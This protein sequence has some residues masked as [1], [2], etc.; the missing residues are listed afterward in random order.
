M[1]RAVHLRAALIA[2][3]GAAALAGA[4][5]TYAAAGAPAPAPCTPTLTTVHGT[6]AT[7]YCGPA[8]V[9]I[10]IGGRTYHFRGGLCDLSTQIGALVLSVGTLVRGAPGNGGRAFVGLVIA[11]SP[12]TSEAFEADAG[13]RQLFGDS[14]IAQGGHLLGRGT[15][16][17]ILGPAFSGSWNCHGVIHSGP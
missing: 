13:G 14:V 2:S 4:A 17:S 16:T 9:V 12:S 8:T 15:F 10:A 3:L 1:R 5:A 6:P 11:A 7:A